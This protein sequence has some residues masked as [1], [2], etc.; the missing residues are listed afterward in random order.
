MM[1]QDRQ[2]FWLT[3][4]SPISDPIQIGAHRCMTDSMNVGVCHAAP[5]TT[6]EVPLLRA[7]AAFLAFGPISALVVLIVFIDLASL[8]CLTR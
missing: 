4:V 2:A 8:P 6:H 7:P 5:H 1:F 3:A